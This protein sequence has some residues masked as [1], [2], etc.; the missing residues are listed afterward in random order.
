M[1]KSVHLY[2]TLALLFFSARIWVQYLPKSATPTLN[3]NASTVVGIACA[4][5]SGGLQNLSKLPIIRTTLPTFIAS[6]E[7]AFIYRFYFAYDDADPF[8]NDELKR[9]LVDLEFKHEATKTT[10]QRLQV[11]THWVECN[12]T[13][14]PAWAQNDAALAAFRDGAEYVFRTNDDTA[15]PLK[16]TS[17]FI[18]DLSL[19]RPVP[20]LGVVG[21]HCPQGNTRILTHD[22][23]HRT[24]VLIHG[25]YYPR[26]LPTWWADDWITRVYQGFNHTLMVKRHDVVVVHT[27][28][29]QR[30]LVD[31]PS[32]IKSILSNEIMIGRNMI[33]NYVLDHF[34]THL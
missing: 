12:Y 15:L 5:H 8:F 31:S 18:N 33:R 3:Q 26:S 25:F 13:G 30:Y 20:N 23:V 17:I 16:W 29:K 21:P 2:F 14:K 10:N 4:V 28:A 24:H 34:N 11:E 22:F 27:L 1:F 32:N 7:P 9:N 19:R 6:A